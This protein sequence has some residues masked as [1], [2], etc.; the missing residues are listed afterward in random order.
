MVYANIPFEKE[1]EISRV[2]VIHNPDGSLDF[3]SSFSITTSSPSC[4]LIATLWLY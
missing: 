3:G 2:G 4:L 1:A